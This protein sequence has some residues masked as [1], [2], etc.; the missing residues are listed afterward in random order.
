MYS[1]TCKHVHCEPA[2]Y[3]YL[4]CGPWRFQYAEP[5]EAHCSLTVELVSFPAAI[6]NL[7]IRWT[8]RVMAGD[9][10][11]STEWIC[12]I[13]EGHMVEYGRK[14][15]KEYAV[16]Q[17]TLRMDIEILE[18]YDAIGSR[19]PWLGR[20][21]WPRHNVVGHGGGGGDGEYN[22]FV[23]MSQMMADIDTL[24]GTVCALSAG[25]SVMEMV[26][27]MKSEIADLKEALQRL[28][29]Q[30][31]GDHDASDLGMVTV[32][33][34]L[35]ES[36]GLPQYLGAFVQNGYESLEFVKAISAKE[37]LSEI[38]IVLKGH[39]TQIMAKIKQL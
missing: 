39:Q 4:E 5:H 6:K 29:G 15:P 2:R 32:E 17:L 8:V 23:A 28:R 18:I 11:R 13:T 34:W 30:R 14:W 19:V 10:D 33:R 31:V 37:E 21:H 22:E 1:V 3:Y 27:S 12:S 24:K 36:V 25:G 38:G 9:I 20:R 26:E 7:K 35:T 16:E